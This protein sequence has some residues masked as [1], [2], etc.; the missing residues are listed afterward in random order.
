[1]PQNNHYRCSYILSTQVNKFNM[2]MKHVT[3]L[4]NILVDVENITNYYKA[5]TIYVSLA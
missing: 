1:M 3:S 5:S 4:K 2:Y